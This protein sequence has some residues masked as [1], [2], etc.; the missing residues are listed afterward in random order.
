MGAVCGRRGDYDDSVSVAPTVDAELGNK[1]LVSTDQRNSESFDLTSTRPTGDPLMD[2]KDYMYRRNVRSILGKRARLFLVYMPTGLYVLDLA[3]ATPIMV[4]MLQS[5]DQGLFV[6]GIIGVS[7]VLGQ[8]WV[9]HVL[10]VHY[11]TTLRGW[12][13]R[14]LGSLI[15]RCPPCTR[16]PPPS[17]VHKEKDFWLV[18][19]AVRFGPLG[20]PVFDVLVVLYVVDLLP[21]SMKG[22]N[23]LTA[24]VS[25]YRSSREPLAAY[26]Q[27]L[28]W[29]FLLFQ[30]VQSQRWGDVADAGLDA[31]LVFISMLSSA[32]VVCVH[33]YTLF[34]CARQGALAHMW[35]KMDMSVVLPEE[36]IQLDIA[37]EIR[38]GIY[39]KG[40]E[41]EHLCALL[42]N[43]T[44]VYS[45]VIKRTV[46]SLDNK[47]PHPVT[48]PLAAIMGALLSRDTYAK[49]LD[50]GGRELS[51]Y[52]AAVLARGLAANTGV[53]SI[54]LGANLFGDVAAESLGNALQVNSS[55]TSL[56][57]NRNAISAIGAYALGSSVAVNTTLKELNLRANMLEDEGAQRLA[58]ALRSRSLLKL[59]LCDNGIGDPGCTAI[60][61]ALRGNGPLAELRLSE[62]RIRDAG[63]VAIAQ[64]LIQ[65][66]RRLKYLGLF[67]NEIGERGAS[68]LARAVQLDCSLEELRLGRNKFGNSGASALGTALLDNTNLRLLNL[69]LNSLTDAA[70]KKLASGLRTNNTLTALDLV[71]NGIG[72]TGA[73]ALSSA[74][75]HNLT[76]RELQL[77][78]NHVSNYAK[79]GL[80]KTWTERGK[81]MVRNPRDLAVYESELTLY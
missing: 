77:G 45:V 72:D 47:W 57:M 2:W 66:N 21:Q 8:M 56:D 42:A 37:K 11:I 31:N 60:A 61:K 18:N 10:V 5:P 28:G 38:L 53:E 20:T 49:H 43:N 36:E 26:L 25:S 29:A 69:R 23:D 16:T 27:S 64:A 52:G 14:L 6:R 4:A 75:E 34:V 76:L 1:P 63:A 7:L 50:V 9:M 13:P 81:E 17:H 46:L 68:A 73:L 3:L 54:Y 44:S 35:S 19:L 22:S 78:F 71:F 67:E 79:L 12:P 65:K 80:R 40:S 55:L 59:D 32:V 41:L 62:N 48:D 51:D 58:T 39:P 74:L 30:L 24:L 15:V 33:F 70:A